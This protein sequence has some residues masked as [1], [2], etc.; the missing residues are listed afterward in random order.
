MTRVGVTLLLLLSVVGGRATAQTLQLVVA[1]AVPDPSGQTV[2]VTG[3]NFGSRPLVTVDLIPVTVQFAL[4]SQLV[5]SVPVAQMPPGTYLVTVSRGPSAAENGS[6]VLTLARPSTSARPAEPPLAD[7]VLSSSATD[8]AARVGDTTMT[9]A[10]VD[11]EWART[12]PAAYLIASRRLYEAR[13]R[14]AD[15]MI[16][17]RVL[18]AEAAVRGLSV[19]ALL[20]EEIPKHTIPMPD[21]AVTSLYLGLGD[22]TRG[23]TLDQ[24]RPAIRA[25]LAKNTEPEMAKMNYVEELMK[26]STRAEVLLVAPRIS[27]ERTAQDAALGPATAPVEVVAFGDFESEGYAALARAFTQ[28]REMFGDRLRL[29][30]KHLPVLGPE[31]AAVAEAA[32]C[33]NQQGQ[34]WA[35]HD[36]IISQPGPFSGPRL[37]QIARDAKIPLAPF[38]ACV[39]EGRSRP[40][41]Q[42]AIEEAARYGI[43][44]SPSILV[45][46]RLA[47]APP[48][49]LP[50]L[51]YFKRIIEEELQRQTKDAAT[52][53]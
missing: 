47:P 2:T 9:L 33:A 43:E 38:D 28:V 1:S 32:A 6:S 11:R 22:R 46:G 21:A 14:V 44:D 39:D 29:V 5:A 12:E 34:F 19:D 13:R 35:Y 4:D 17:D 50:P 27:V 7:A 52:R 31:S 53:R 41:I 49:F 25:W 30:F 3:T 42:Q 48:A 10:D 16:T 36:A 20:A 51:Q 15:Q 45:N 26:V 37:K 24:M 18:A 8:A 23:A 40:V